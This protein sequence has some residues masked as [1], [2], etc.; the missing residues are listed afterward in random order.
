MPNYQKRYVQYVMSSRISLKYYM[1]SPWPSKGIMSCLRQFLLFYCKKSPS[2]KLQKK[3]NNF[4]TDNNSLKFEDRLIIFY[5][6][7]ECKFSVSNQFQYFRVYPCLF[8]S[9]C[10]SLRKMQSH[11]VHDITVYI[12][13]NIRRLAGFQLVNIWS[14]SEYFGVC[15]CLTVFLLFCR[16][17]AVML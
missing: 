1:T 6:Q 4:I 9:M 2:K 5:P 8:I 16:Q 12:R 3:P 13:D 7:L 15:Y 11:L 17:V 14:H 10:I